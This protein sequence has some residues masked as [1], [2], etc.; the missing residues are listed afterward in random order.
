LAEYAS[1]FA[2][3]LRIFV[4]AG[5]VTAMHGSLRDAKEDMDARNMWGH[6]G[7]VASSAA[8]VEDGTAHDQAEA[9]RC[10]HLHQR[11][12][13]QGV[14]ALPALAG[15]PRNRIPTDSR[16]VTP[17]SPAAQ[18]FQVLI[19]CSLAL[20]SVT[21]SSSSIPG[22]ITGKRHIADAN[23]NAA[24]PHPAINAAVSRYDFIIASRH[25]GQGWRVYR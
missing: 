16:A 14:I 21:W 12:A 4:G 5:L 22:L 3:R 8:A 24:E 19:L 10:L 6:D 2:L 23:Q 11:F 15:H 18:K 9:K 1:L 20:N 13:A 7:G 17:M 25:P